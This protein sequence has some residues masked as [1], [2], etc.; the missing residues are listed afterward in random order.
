M[1]LPSVATSARWVGLR[2]AHKERFA[3]ELTLSSDGTTKKDVAAKNSSAALAGN[4]VIGQLLRL[5]SAEYIYYRSTKRRAPLSFS[6]G[7]AAIARR[8]RR[9]PVIVDSSPS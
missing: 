3:R 2:R 6:P 7:V 1:K 5:G 8:V 4:E 9:V